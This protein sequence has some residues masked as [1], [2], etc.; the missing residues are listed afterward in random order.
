MNKQ[1][2]K[3][4][5]N[6][7]EASIIFTFVILMI[8]MMSAFTISVISVSTMKG[9]RSGENSAL[10]LYAADTGMERGMFEYWWSKD[11]GTGCNSNNATE[12]T[13]SPTKYSLFIDNGVAGGCPLVSDINSDTSVHPQLCIEAIGTSG[14]TERKLTS[15]T[16]KDGGA[17]CVFK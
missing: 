17:A 11:D 1:Q 3:N 8:V 13:I 2:R 4:N 12:T 9:A 15:A 6:R 16:G 7:G 5:L 14:T 10:A